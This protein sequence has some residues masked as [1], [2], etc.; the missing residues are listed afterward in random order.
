M[1][2]GKISNM[3]R[4]VVVLMLLSLLFVGKGTAQEF[5]VGTYNIF[6]AES[7]MKAVEADSRVSRQRCWCNSASAVGL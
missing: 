4:K 5:K 6:D 7:R 1:V 3:S 2:N